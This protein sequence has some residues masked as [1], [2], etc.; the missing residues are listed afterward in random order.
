MSDSTALVAAIRRALM[1]RDGAI[2]IYDILDS[3]NAE[4]KRRAAEDPSPTLYLART[5]TNGRGRLGRSFY[6][7]DTGMYMTLSVTTDRPPSEALPVTAMAAVATAA[8]IE[9]LT[10]RTPGIKWVNDLYLNGAKLAGI[11]AESLPCADGRT[12]ILVG[13]G[14]NLTTVDFPAELRAPAISL[15]AAGEEHLVT[16]TLIGTLAGTIAR[17][18]LALIAQTPYAEVLPTG[19][20]ALSFYRRHLLYV[21]EDILCTRG[22]DRF[23]GILRGVDEH[24]SLLVETADGMSSLHSGEISIRVAE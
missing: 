1:H 16:D 19:E 23:A 2:R 3:T 4:A 9:A 10:D 14:I 24:Y 21:G 22:N 12:R 5:Q 8:A 20:C 7:P 17:S 15:F 13:I 11:L 18:L 6:S